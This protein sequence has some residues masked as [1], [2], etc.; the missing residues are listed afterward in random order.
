MFEV[1]LKYPLS[2]VAATT[3]S[4]ERLSARFRPAIE[5][6]DRYFAHP[7][8][9][10]ARVDEA[11]RLRR[12]G[13]TVVVT[14]KGPRLGAG[15]KT[16]REIELPVEVAAGQG[17]AA[18]LDRWTELLEALGFHPVREVVKTRRPARLPWQ[19]AEVEVA[20][21]T[22]AH[23]GDFLELELMAGEGQLPVALSCLA[24]VAAELGCGEPEPR[25]YLELL[26]AADRPR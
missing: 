21:D 4:L 15:A 24:S 10:F 11:L 2:D 3:A 25:S 5:Q 20:I 12:A 13:G 19:G 8:R 22:V 7:S 23:L 16:R 17:A 1:E 6:T 18:T 14:W 26:L 9:D